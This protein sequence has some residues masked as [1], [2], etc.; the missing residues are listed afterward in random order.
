MRRQNREVNIFNMSL[1]DILCGALGAFCFMMLALFP[2]YINAAGGSRGAGDAE[3]RA[4]TA[5]EARDK[6]QAEQSLVYF[7]IRW[8]TADDVDLWLKQASGTYCAN[9][10]DAPQA[11]TTDCVVTDDALKGPA[12]E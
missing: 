7:Q 2:S 9:K 4:K 8:D 5:E 10:K 11:K 12:S 1:L 6:A 3:Q